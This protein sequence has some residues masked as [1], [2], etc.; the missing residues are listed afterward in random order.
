MIQRITLIFQNARTDQVMKSWMGRQRSQAI[1][2]VKFLQP[3]TIRCLCRGCSH[4]SGWSS[5][6]HIACPTHRLVSLVPAHINFTSLILNYSTY[7]IGPQTLDSGKY[8]GK[9]SYEPAKSTKSNLRGPTLRCDWHFWTNKT[10]INYLIF[11]GHFTT[12]NFS[13]DCSKAVFSIEI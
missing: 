1:W 4:H 12:Y 8:Q 9:L 5:S 3:H 13:L 10:I 7:N 6:T 11:W 2:S